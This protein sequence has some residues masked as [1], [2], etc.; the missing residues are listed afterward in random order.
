[1][2]CDKLLL[3]KHNIIDKINK[4]RIKKINNIYKKLLCNLQ[5]GLQH[6]FPINPSCFSNVEQYIED[7]NNFE[8]SKIIDTIK[9]GNSLEITYERCSNSHDGDYIKI[10]LK[11]LDNKQPGTLEFNIKY[12][13]DIEDYNFVKF[14]LTDKNIKKHIKNIT[15]K[16][17]DHL[18]NMFD[19][20]ESFDSQK[21]TPSTDEDKLCKIIKYINNLCKFCTKMCRYIVN[22]DNKLEIND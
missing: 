17:I 20:C 8:S 1:M 19:I 14:K 10:M 11:K 16:M 3:R 13:V 2:S 22:I 4:Y 21:L 5:T 7:D 9:I 12:H 15:F 6:F 18:G